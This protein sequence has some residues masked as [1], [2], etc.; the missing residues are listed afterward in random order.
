MRGPELF[1]IPFVTVS[2]RSAC[3]SDQGALS[4]F[5]PTFGKWYLAYNM[6]VM[7]PL[8]PH[9]A[10]PRSTQLQNKTFLLVVHRRKTRGFFKTGSFKNGSRACRN[11]TFMGCDRTK[12]TYIYYSTS[13]VYACRCWVKRKA[14]CHP[15][16][17]WMLQKSDRLAKE[18]VCNTKW[19]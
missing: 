5:S 9:L 6:R 11:G 16:R 4:P 12:H 18:F 2:Q 17:F 15:L 1:L 14:C 13:Y 10:R 7:L 19:R 8:R 3:R